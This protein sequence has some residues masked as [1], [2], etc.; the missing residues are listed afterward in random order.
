MSEVIK[1]LWANMPEEPLQWYERF[2]VYYLPGVVDQ[3]N[4]LEIAY[5][6]FLESHG[7][8][9]KTKK[10]KVPKEWQDIAKK[11][12]WKNRAIEF[13]KAQ[14]KALIAS[15]K[16]V[17]QD[18]IQKQIELVRDNLQ[19]WEYL[20][21]QYDTAYRDTALGF[22]RSSDTVNAIKSAQMFLEMSQYTINQLTELSGIKELLAEKEKELKSSG[23]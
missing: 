17:I 5:D 19:R 16:K 1:E 3:D 4:S 6:K 14:A 7:K 23:K 9:D 18:I 11:Y 10:A 12:H 2:V 13:K 20:S 22:R 15:E 8:L 21:S